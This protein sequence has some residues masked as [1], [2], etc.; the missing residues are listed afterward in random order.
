VLV[1]PI[2]VSSVVS[3][4]TSR[5][6]RRSKR[7]VGKRACRRVLAGALLLSGAAACLAA[8]L[9]AFTVDIGPESIVLQARYNKPA[10]FPHRA[11]QDWYGCTA[12]HHVKDQVMTIDK[13]EGCHN[14]AMGNPQ[15]DSLRKAG[16]VLC[17]GCHGREREKGRT[18]APSGCSGCHPRSA[19]E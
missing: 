8:P 16:H 7:A 12:C 10:L 13:C 9:H 15:L 6:P 18:S 11:H 19:P 2:G 5:S 3:G 14:D 17:R 1:N 4:R